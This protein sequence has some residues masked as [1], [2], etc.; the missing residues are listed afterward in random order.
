[1]RVR[2]LRVAVLSTNNDRDYSG[3]RYHG[4][5]LACAA[6]AGGAEVRYVTDRRP[7]FLGDLAPL[8]PGRVEVQIVG[9]WDE[10]LDDG[11]LD[12]LV[13][14]PAGIAHPAF[15]AAALKLAGETG[16]RIALVNFETA[17]WFNAMSPVPRDP[18]LWDGWRLMV[19]RGGL[20]LSSART[21]DAAARPFYAHAG[22]AIRFEV[23]SPPINAPA[24]RAVFGSEKAPIVVAFART[25]DPHKGAADLLQLDPRSL[26]DNA[27]HIVSGGD[28]DSRFAAALVERFRGRVQFHA[29]LSD[30]DK[31]RLLAS[32]RALV[33]PSRFEGFGYP[34]VEACFAGTEVAAYD[35]PVLRETVGTVAH[36]APVGD[37]AA[38]GAALHRARGSP[39][40]QAAL[41]QAVEARVDFGPAAARLAEILWRSLDAVQPRT[42]HATS[43]QCRVTAARAPRLLTLAVEPGT[44]IAR[45]TV[46]RWPEGLIRHVVAASGQDGVVEVE[47]DLAAPP[48]GNGAL[49]VGDADGSRSTPAFP[50]PHRADNPV[51]RL[52]EAAREAG[53]H[54]PPPGL[55]PA[56][57]RKRVLFC[58]IVPMT[59][60]DQGNRAVTFRLVAHLVALGFDVDVVLQGGEVPGAF[61]SHFGDRVRVV[62]SPFPDWAAAPEAQARL[63]RLAEIDRDASL[64]PARRAAF[65]RE[66]STYHPWFVVS[67]AVVEL[68]LGLYRRHDYAA[69]VCNYTHMA[70][71]AKEL[72]LVRPLPPS[73]IVTHDALSRLD[74]DIKGTPV[75]TMYRCCSPETE[76]DVLNAIGG[77][78]VLAISEDERDYFSSIGVTRSLVVCEYDGY[79]EVRETPVPETG[80]AQ[81]RLVFHGSANPLNIAALDWFVERCWR[82]ILAR[83]P[84]ARLTI[85]GKIAA[86][87]SRVVPNL[88]SA[89]L[90]DRDQLI[91][92]LRAAS[93]AI[94]PALAGTGLKIK[95]VEAACLGLPAVCLPR[96]VDGLMD[97]ADRFAIVAQDEAGFIAGCI[98]LLTDAATWQRLHASALEFAAER[99]SSDRVYRA[100]DEAMGWN[101]GTG[102]RRL[103]PRRPGSRAR[104]VEEGLAAG[105]VALAAGD[106][107]RAA[108]CGAAAV[109]ADPGDSQGYRLIALGLRDSGDQAGAAEAA[110]RALHAAPA[111]PES[112]MLALELA[113]EPL[114]PLRP[115]IEAPIEIAVGETRPFRFP[116]PAA[117]FGWAYPETWGCWTAHRQARIVLHSANP[118]GEALVALLHLHATDDGS[119]DD[120]I[121]DLFVDGK[122]AGALEIKRDDMAQD[123]VVPLPAGAFGLGGRVTIDLWI[124]RPAVKRQDGE[125]VDRRRLGVALSAITL[126]KVPPPDARR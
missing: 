36:L 33:F 42:R 99:F 76:R 34:P 6:A 28:V 24:A 115:W 30:V 65:R 11:P 90:V 108:A 31:F 75:D 56:A 40:R 53:S 116:T 109:A 43:P 27:L 89:G 68:A 114:A 13:V 84:T 85:C 69:L 92:T 63:A 21:A 117:G 18:A 83:V 80:F 67:D 38:L 100:L 39:G 35:L 110:I 98:Q 44:V 2:R 1:M 62:S 88:D 4:M 14:V 16:A 49:A 96:A 106:A 119:G 64:D 29:R 5:M 59:P 105:R 26:G 23:W 50:T 60:V 72:E 71:V 95:T 58:T 124:H 118:E 61:I 86:S 111:D 20:V 87:W 66:A 55:V 25:A 123:Y 101:A 93:I 70:R 57:D 46:L 10:A 45:G 112:M 54:L 37:V 74:L 82:E 77:A 79:A 81:Q 17:N 3:G 32:A 113:P 125:I 52:I 107:G 7:V 103:Q 19:R 15:Y 78:V 97:V 104:D 51:D 121:V 126:S 12:W 120:Q 91:E 41:L 122:A 22:A 8:A 102:S 47:L 9:G 73:V 48:P 94:N